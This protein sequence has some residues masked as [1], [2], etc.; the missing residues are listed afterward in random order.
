[1]ELT[2]PKYF[3]PGK[4]LTYE[5]DSCDSL[6][7]AWINKELE[8]STLAR[9]TYPGKELLEGELTGIKSIGYWDIK[10]LQN[11]GLD[12]HSN[13]GIEICFLESG[14]LDFQIKNHE[15]HLKTNDITITRPW[16][17]H[18]IG[19]PLVNLS[20]LHWL[21]LDV[22][23][24]HPHQNWEWPEWVVL[25]ENDL[26]ELTRYL[27]QNEQPVWK[28]GND[29]KKCFVQI[30]N[31]I[32][33]SNQKP[34]DSKLKIQINQL[35]ILLLEIFKEGNIVL[36]LS[37]VE[38][39]RSVELFLSSIKSR[40]EEEWTVVKMAEDC[41]LGVTR[42]THYCKEITNCSP[43]E[44]L[45]RLRLRKASRLLVDDIKIPVID[46]AFMCGFSST[47]YFNYV[48]KKHFKLS[49]NQFRKLK[50]FA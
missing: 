45:N 11:W 21:I 25:N 28:A 31:I 40:I 20:K 5:A 33:Q 23:V 12:W 8:L 34:Y 26:D 6:R 15:Y 3:D 46:V 14:N 9:G 2:V 41:H 38:T 47:Q 49:P 29:F 48:F 32:K 22:K 39:K 7:E 13:E 27:R 18:K 4:N 19:S 17:T 50:N 37:L 24:R 44:Y 30:G 1:M 42:F 16:I 36:D 35:L 43:M 10:K